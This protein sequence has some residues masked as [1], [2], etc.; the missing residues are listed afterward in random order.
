M[1]AVEWDRKQQRMR[2][3]RGWARSEAT[4][5]PLGFTLRKMGRSYL[6][7]SRAG[8]GS[9]VHLNRIPLASGLRPGCRGQGWNKDNIS[10]VSIQIQELADRRPWEAGRFRY[11]L[12]DQATGFVGSSDTGWEGKGAKD[13]A[14]SDL[15]EDSTASLQWEG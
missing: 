6:I 11:I 13:A 9:D 10:K 14:A 1:A 8:T 2:S 15:C 5:S 7:L 12:K 3:E 4:V